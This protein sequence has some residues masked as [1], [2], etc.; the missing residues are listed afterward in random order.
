VRLPLA[1]VLEHQHAGGISWLLVTLLPAGIAAQS[2]TVLLLAALAAVAAG[3][4]PADADAVQAEQLTQQAAQQMLVHCM[5]AQPDQ[6][7][8][9]AEAACCPAAHHFLLALLAA[10]TAAARCMPQR[11]EAELPVHSLA[12]AEAARQGS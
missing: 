12:Q 8:L 3:L 9:S 1:V 10:D 11:A 2:A 7:Q 5:V 6:V 4:P